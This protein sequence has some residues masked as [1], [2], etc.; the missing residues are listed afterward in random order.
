MER[1]DRFLDSHWPNVI[2]AHVLI[3]TMIAAAVV[4]GMGW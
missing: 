1:L 3:L 4:K 2:A